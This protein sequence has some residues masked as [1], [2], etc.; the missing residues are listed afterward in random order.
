MSFDDNAIKILASG[1]VAVIPTNTIY[2][3][4]DS[5]LSVETVDLIL[6]YS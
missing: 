5:I 4:I 6:R 2:G 3:V 1:S